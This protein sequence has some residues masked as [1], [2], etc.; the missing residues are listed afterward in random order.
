MQFKQEREN[1]QSEKNHTFQGTPAGIVAIIKSWLQHIH[2]H[3]SQACLSF[4]STDCM[5]D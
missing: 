4:N 2:M 3:I 1:R 5:N